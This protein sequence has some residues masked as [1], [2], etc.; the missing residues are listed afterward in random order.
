M[1]DTHSYKGWLNSDNFM[2]RALA[3]MGYNFIAALVVWFGLFVF[4]FIIGVLVS[5]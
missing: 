4:F 3:V 2:K 1:K 5:I